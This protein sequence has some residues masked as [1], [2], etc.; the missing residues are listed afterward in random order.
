MSVN[1][2]KQ[3]LLEAAI[4][5]VAENGIGDLSLRELA[6]ALG[7]SHRMLIH[8]FGSKEG[9]WVEIVRT[10]EERQRELLAPML[11]ESTASVGDVIR[12]WWKHISDPALWANERL[13]FELYGQALQ[14]RPH[15]TAL[16]DGIVKDWVEPVAEANI[17]NGMAPAQARAHARLG[18]A[19]CRGLLLDL[20]AT[21]ETAEVD[22]AN[23]VFIEL[24][25]AWLATVP[26]QSR[27]V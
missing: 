24:Y 6:S 25:E 18:V 20:L 11:P 16:L 27:M 3:R 9:L 21:H 26:S 2:P 1:T 23:E 13:F 5:Y 15:T 8:H 14:N 7:T 10:V 22:A 12:A 19:V 17:S 4:D